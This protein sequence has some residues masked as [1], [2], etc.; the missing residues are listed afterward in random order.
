MDREQTIQQMWSR[1][2]RRWMDLPAGGGPCHRPG[3]LYPDPDSNYRT[4]RCP[5]GYQYIQRGLPCCQLIHK[6]KNT[7]VVPV[8]PKFQVD[9]DR[10]RGRWDIDRSGIP[11]TD[12]PPVP[13]GAVDMEGEDVE[14]GRFRRAYLKHKPN[15]SEQKV[16]AKYMRALRVASGV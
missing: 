13:V 8:P 16:R 14:F 7:A 3:L 5:D 4:P 9:E 10:V 15:T 12:L 6:R 2:I 1:A 11:R